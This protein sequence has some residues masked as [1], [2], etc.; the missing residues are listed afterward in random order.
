MGYSEEMPAA[1]AFRDA[2]IN[3]IFEGTNE[4][5]RLLTVDMLLK[6]ALKGHIDLMSPAMQVQKELMAIP[7]FGPG[8]DG[9]FSREKKLVAN[10]KKA[11][12]M[13]AGAA[14]Q[15]LMMALEHEQEILIN[16][17]NMISELYICESILLRAEK[18]KLSGHPTTNSAS[19]MMQV[20]LF[21]AL[22]RI[23]AEGKNAIAA[24]AEGDELNMLQLG[25]KRFT[26]Q[27]LINT[28]LLRRNIASELI[29]ANRYC[30]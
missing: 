21:D 7:D 11:V 22:M 18:L 10:M 29:L 12:L 4:I 8:D 15:K 28:K 27:Q 2:R 14:V 30:Y 25:L 20:Y 3:R 19:N 17:A 16:I 13:T 26:K 1:R 5:N 9:L 24:F 6:R 23:E